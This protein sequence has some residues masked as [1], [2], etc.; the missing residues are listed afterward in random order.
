MI[1]TPDDWNQWMKN[2]VP[3]EDA[4]SY[5]FKSQ[6][7]VSP[8]NGDDNHRQDISHGLSHKPIVHNEGSDYC[9]LLQ[10][11]DPVL[12]VGAKPR[13]CTDAVE[14][15]ISAAHRKLTMVAQASR[16]TVGSWR[17]TIL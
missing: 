6:Q 7:Q 10:R 13:P 2:N 12:A 17:A 3:S 5:L 4:A 11:R 16:A 1:E 15:L 9:L 8:G 14:R